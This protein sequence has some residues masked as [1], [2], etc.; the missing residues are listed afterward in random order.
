LKKWPNDGNEQNKKVA[1]SNP[2]KKIY[3]FRAWDT[4]RYGFLGNMPIY[5][6]N[7]EDVFA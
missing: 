7:A 5:R 1:E 4:I 2:T 3:D 6:R